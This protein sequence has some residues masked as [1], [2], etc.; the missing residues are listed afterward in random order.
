MEEE[1]KMESV[2]VNSDE[3][4]LQNSKFGTKREDT[5]NKAEI[6]E[7]KLSEMS[8]KFKKRFKDSK[9]PW[10]ERLVI[11][12]ENNVEFVDESRINDDVQREV[13]FYNI[14]LG[15]VKEALNKISKEGLKLDRPQDYMADMFKDDRIMTKIRSSLVKQQVRSRNFEEQ[16][17]KKYA[18]KIQKR[19]LH[20]K[21]LQASKSKEET[22]RAIKKWHGDIKKK[23]GSEKVGDLDDYIKKE[24][25]QRKKSSKQFHNMKGKK[26]KKGGVRPGKNKRMKSINKKKSRKGG[27]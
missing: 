26:I 27:K 11:T 19:R 6:M 15:N 13:Q 10:S 12:S 16:K 9:I 14:C 1:L 21:N 24:T 5:I 25:E 17:L 4:A 20:M 3:I 18:K 7:Q 8:K 23:G 22:N 2:S